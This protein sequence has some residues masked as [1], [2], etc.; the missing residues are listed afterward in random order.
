M[1]QKEIEI[2][3]TRQLASYLALPIFIVDPEGNLIFY[4]ERAELI[5]GQQFEETGE[6]PAETWATIFR[7][8]D[9]KGE[10]LAAESLPLMV[11]LAERRPAHRRFWIRGLDN[12]LR[13]IEVSAFPIVGQA[14]RHLGALALF[15]E[16]GA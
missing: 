4:N 15:W 3:L 13:H 14:D 11:A 12:V 6:M 2:I 5:L 10:L 16:V 7:P 8:I 9:E 1:S